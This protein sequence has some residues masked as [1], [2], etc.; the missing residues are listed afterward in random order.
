MSGESLVTHRR[1]TA[2]EAGEDS[3]DTKRGETPTRLSNGAFSGAGRYGL[4]L[5]LWETQVT[6]VKLI[7]L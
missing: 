2:R 3:W 4:W 7:A 6:I 1:E 5:W